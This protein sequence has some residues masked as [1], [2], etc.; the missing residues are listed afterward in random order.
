MS[1]S[2]FL[3]QLTASDIYHVMEPIGR[4][5]CGFSVKRD[6]IFGVYFIATRETMIL[7]WADIKKRVS[8][9]SNT[10]PIKEILNWVC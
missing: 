10:N 3:Q 2:S 4:S 7:G 5:G 6:S 9:S 8:L 1:L